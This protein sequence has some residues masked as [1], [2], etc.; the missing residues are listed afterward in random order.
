MIAQ[1]TDGCSRGFLM[2]GVLRGEKM[3]SF[4]DLGK[5]AMERHPPL[6]DWVRG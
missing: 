5:S 4:V 2:E 3:L 6:V 1:G